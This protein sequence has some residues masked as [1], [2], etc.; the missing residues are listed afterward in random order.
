MVPS[1]V[2]T[3]LDAL[4]AKNKVDEAEK[5]HQKDSLDILHA[6]ILAE[7][8][9]DALQ[10]RLKL[11]EE[12]VSALEF[13][14]SLFQ[15]N[16]SRW[17]GGWYNGD[18]NDGDNNDGDNDDDLRSGDY[19]PILSRKRGGW[20]NDKKRGGWYYRFEGS[21]DGDN[22]DGVDGVD[23]FN[24]GRHTLLPPLHDILISTSRLP[25][26]HNTTLQLDDRK[27]LAGILNSKGSGGY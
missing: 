8:K 12:R 9:E 22:D 1:L 25:G 4:L 13:Q 26:G 19:P 21:D 2:N 18:N 6:E 3:K 11:I 15:W 23:Y 20:K 7:E 24:N 10:K 5:K 17:R 27:L 14:L 16:S